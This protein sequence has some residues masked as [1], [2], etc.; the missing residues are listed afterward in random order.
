MEHIPSLTGRPQLCRILYK[1]SSRLWRD[2]SGSLPIISFVSVNSFPGT[3]NYLY[4]DYSTIVY[5]LA[6]KHIFKVG[7]GHPTS[8]EKP[9][10]H[11][12]FPCFF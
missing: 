8:K 12:R 6:Y 1:H 5:L 2:E 4:T 3:S 9:I 7:P 10:N 11:Y